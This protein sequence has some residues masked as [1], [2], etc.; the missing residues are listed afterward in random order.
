MQHTEPKKMTQLSQS[1]WKTVEVDLCGPFPNKKYV[2]V[3]TDQ[4]SRYPEA[5][6]ICSTSIQP[7]RNKLKKP[8]T[9]HG[10]PHKIQAD[11]GP[12]FN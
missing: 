10:I 9:T 1:P 6:F 2:M 3:T 12:P 4:Y 11:K 8:F 5:E 7:A